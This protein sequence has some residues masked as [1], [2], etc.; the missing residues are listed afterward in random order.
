LHELQEGHALLS[1][2]K[3]ITPLPQLPATQQ[4]KGVEV[5]RR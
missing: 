1:E 5:S 4:D 3:S 2:Y